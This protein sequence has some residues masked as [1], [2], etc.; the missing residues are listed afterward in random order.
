[1]GK[2]MTELLKGTLEGIVLALLAVQPDHLVHP[3][4]R[5]G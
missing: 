4:P 3:G 2:Q 1:M 5:L